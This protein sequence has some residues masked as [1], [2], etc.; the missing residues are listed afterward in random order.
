MLIYVDLGLVN[1]VGATVIIYYQESK[2][3][4]KTGSTT[5]NRPGVEGAVLQ[6]ALSQTELERM[7]IPHNAS[8]VTRHMSGV[9]IFFYKVW[10]LAGIY[11]FFYKVWELAGGGSV[12]NKAYPI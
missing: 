5:I 1:G 12:V 7:F 4:S 6:T 11:M 8:H 2:T 10:E 3:I 9:Y